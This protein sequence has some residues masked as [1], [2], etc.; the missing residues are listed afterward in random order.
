MRKSQKINNRYKEKN[1]VSNKI[2]NLEDAI[3][4][5][6]IILVEEL[7]KQKLRW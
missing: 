2:K 5:N 6:N 7:L 4:S 1:G 3:V